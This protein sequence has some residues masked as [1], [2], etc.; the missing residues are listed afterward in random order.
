MDAGTF[1]CDSVMKGDMFT[2]SDALRKAGPEFSILGHFP[3]K[4]GKSFALSVSHARRPFGG[5]FRSWMVERCAPLHLFI[6]RPVRGI[7]SMLVSLFMTY[8][9]CTFQ[10]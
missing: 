9:I 5:V 3:F 6:P 10:H 4:Q 2:S 7:T 8:Q 1:R